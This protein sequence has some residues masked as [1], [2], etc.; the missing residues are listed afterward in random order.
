MR[1]TTYIRS[2]A[3]RIPD[4]SKGFA[5][6]ISKLNKSQGQAGKMV[7][8]PSDLIFV[9][10][11]R[12]NA[13]YKM[14]S[15]IETLEGKTLNLK[16]LDERDITFT[17]H[18]TDIVSFFKSDVVFPSRLTTQEKHYLR[19]ISSDKNNIRLDY[20]FS[21]LASI[22]WIEKGIHSP[23][24]T[25]IFIAKFYNVSLMDYDI[26]FIKRLSS[27]ESFRRELQEMISTRSLSNHFHP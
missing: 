8:S 16:I 25:Y 27:R 18:T 12:P 11:N 2:L 26:S 21:S 24:T 4:L 5:M 7:G 6:K 22:L 17:V 9:V 13:L 19:K 10:S 3:R 15:L 23:E 1:K 20:K 14:I